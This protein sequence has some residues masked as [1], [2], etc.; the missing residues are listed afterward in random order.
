MICIGVDFVTRV[1]IAVAF[2][3]SF[4][5]PAFAQSQVW[6]QIEAQ[7]DIR[8]T[9]ER[10]R[11]YARQ[12][13]DTQAYLTPTGWY[14]IVIGPMGE[15][16]ANREMKRLKSANQIPRDSFIADGRGFQNQ[17]WPLNANTLAMVAA[18]NTVVIEGPLDSAESDVDTDAD[19]DGATNVVVI[20][21]PEPAPMPEPEPTPKKL[22]KA[23]QALQRS[24]NRD[25]KK[26]IQTALAWSGDYKSGI[27]GAFGPGTRAAISAFQ[28][29]NGFR[30][31]AVLTQEEA[32]LVEVQR[33]EKIQR[34]GIEVVSDLDAGIEV[35]MPT[36]LVNQTRFDP[37][38]VHYDG[39]NNSNVSVTLISQEGN[40]A[41]L[42]SLYDIMET[43]DVVPAEGYRVKKRDWFALSGRDEQTVS[44]TYARLKNNLIKGFTLVWTPELDRDMEPVAVAMY[45]SFSPIDAYVLDETL[46]FGEGEDG[47]LDL[48]SGLETLAPDSA[49]TGFF[50]A[51]GGVVLTHLDNIAQCSRVTLGDDVEME[52]IARAP[53]NGIAVLRPVG[54]FAPHAFARF[55]NLEPRAGEDVILAGYTYP[56]EVDDSSIYY[57]VV[58][59]PLTEAGLMEVHVQVGNGDRGGPLL[60]DR[61]AVVGLQQLRDESDADLPEY[62]NFA[63]RAADITAILDRHEIPYVR[64]NT[65]DALEPEDMAVLARDFTV[66]VSC[67]N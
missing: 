58:E 12:F 2:V 63:A 61:G 18:P 15:A 19:T 60:D 29:R 42:A 35:L 62:V 28:E 25:E 51:P 30:V 53:R 37:P 26:A 33:A 39:V 22:L 11:L 49:A 23:A 24:W 21:E 38:F 32:D 59:A 17:L 8:T 67:W 9:R 41:T 43:F 20:S 46:G 40:R 7:P 36:A 1:L 56:L 16:L 45:N 57:G 31:T 48:A 64:A 5:G 65:Y 44:Y 4:F 27:D 55:S 47:P 54:S 50:V 34:L 14:A 66:R 13:G 10:A 52:P 3:V 6:I